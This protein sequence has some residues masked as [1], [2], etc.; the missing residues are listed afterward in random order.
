MPFQKTGLYKVSRH[1]VHTCANMKRSWCVKYS[2][3]RERNAGSDQSSSNITNLK[4]WVVR[5]SGPRSGERHL[6][7]MA[8]ILTVSSLVTVSKSQPSLPSPLPPQRRYCRSRHR[9]TLFCSN[10]SSELWKRNRSQRVQL[11]L[12]VLLRQA[13]A[14]SSKGPLAT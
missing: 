9:R 6:S 12:Q 14:P 5:H 3:K 11:P 4:K 1:R 10:P 2:K 7:D 13:A 8:H